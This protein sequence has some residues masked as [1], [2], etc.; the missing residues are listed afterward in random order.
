MEKECKTERKKE[1]GKYVHEAA[2]KPL[3]IVMQRQLGKTLY[4]VWPT[5]CRNHTHNNV[6]IRCTILVL[7]SMNLM[8]ILRMFVAKFSRFQFNV[9]ERQ[10]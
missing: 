1:R 2:Y 5:L 7:R 8:R 4:T 10:R 9:E 6:K 3:I